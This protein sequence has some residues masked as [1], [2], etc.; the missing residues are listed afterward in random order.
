MSRPIVVFS[1]ALLTFSLEYTVQ[2][3]ALPIVVQMEK[4]T[5]CIGTAPDEPLQPNRSRSDVTMSQSRA[6]AD[7][8]VVAEAQKLFCR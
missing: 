5:C 8:I 4:R 7:R 2:D 3:I 6:M 1:C